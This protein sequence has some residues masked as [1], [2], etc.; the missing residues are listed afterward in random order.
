MKELQRVIFMGTPDFAAESLQRIVEAKYNVIAVVTAPDKPAN[1]GRKI[2]QSAVKKC[3]LA[4]N[5]PVLQPKN[6]KHESFIEKLKFLRADIQVVVAFRMLPEVVWNMPRLGSINLHASLL[7][8]YRGAAPIHWAVINGE[9][10]SGLTTFFLKHEIDTGNIILQKKITISPNETTGE[11]YNKLKR[12][13]ADVLLETLHLVDNNTYS[14][15]P[16]IPTKEDKKAPK[17]TKEVAKINWQ[18]SAKEVHNLI[19][20]L[21]PTPGSYA[22]WNG[23]NVK[24]WKSIYHED[25]NFSLNV[26]EI[27]IKDKKLWVGCKDKPIEIKELQLQNKNRVSSLDFINAYKDQISKTSFTL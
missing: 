11:L 18:K 9:S 17:I 26:G 14:E 5:I 19:R 20:G 13:G 8:N 25:V 22:I 12:I 15:I 7:P 27:H 6:L 23:Q 4:L 10:E 24:F 21:N 3:A 2:Q 1:R 16:Q